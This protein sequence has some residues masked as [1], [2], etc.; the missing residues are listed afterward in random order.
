MNGI[1]R[2]GSVAGK[3]FWTIVVFGIIIAGFW[4]TWKHYSRTG[5]KANV[6]YSKVTRG[7]F[8]HEIVGKGNAQS[9]KNV[10]VTCQ[11]ESNAGT[12]IIWIIPEGEHVQ[13]GD[14]LVVLDSSDLED[15]ASTQQITCNTNSAS[16]ASSRASLRTAEL[17]LEEYIEGTFEQEWMTIEN[18]IYT[19]REEQKKEADSVAY[20]KKLVQFGYTTTVQLESALV[21][22]QKQVNTLKSNLLKQ[23]VLLKYTSEKQITKLMADIETARAKLSSDTYSAE[24]SKNRLDH[25]LQQLEYCV[26]RAPTDGQVVYANDD[27]WRESD[28]IQEGSKVYANH[29]R[30]RLPDPMQMQVKAMVNESNIAHVKVGMKARIVFDALSS[31][32]FEGTV[33]KVNQYPEFKWMSSSKDYVTIIDIDNPSDKIRSGL[34]A[35]VQIEAQRIADVLMLPV[36]CIVEVAKKDYVITY[37]GGQWGYKEVKIGLSNDKQVI[38]EEGLSE[39]D[40]VVSGARQYKNKVHFPG[41]PVK[42][43]SEEGEETAEDNENPAVDSPFG[44]PGAGLG[45]MGGMIA[46]GVT[47]GPPAGPPPGIP[48]EGETPSGPPPAEEKEKTE[49]EAEQDKLLLDYLASLIKKRERDE[50]ALLESLSPYFDMTAM[51][52][53]QMGDSDSDK[54][55]TRSEIAENLPLC[56]P[57]F[58][59]WD[60]SKKGSLT[61]TDL[62]IGF[63][64]AR[65]KYQRMQQTISELDEEESSMKF[66]FKMEPAEIFTFLDRT[67]ENVIDAADTPE[68]E[69]DSFAGLLKRLD[70]NEDGRVN[71][72]E[73][74]KGITR[75][76]QDLNKTPSAK[77]VSNSSGRPPRPR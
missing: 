68:G 43:E 51:E 41:M 76:K 71:A 61:R 73:F 18:E 3:L 14:R 17:S 48:S 11:V 49:E 29:V 10:D 30:V 4:W 65:I 24:V 60:R 54:Q 34:T 67:G 16:V 44:A 21:A 64:S 1:E 57:F 40:Q 27:V 37:S 20:T 33:S 8:V 23:D 12:T 31:E 72:D 63:C 19:A 45:P 58:D 6:I 66:V 36:Q 55:I 56:L 53:C 59:E 32:S 47:G 39:G 46:G 5:G 75:F 50:F 26:V 7:T 28:M 15:K 69:N 9:A 52:V 35:Q 62:V 13:K 22:E 2:R 38:I 42:P 25:F 74:S 70:L 77:G